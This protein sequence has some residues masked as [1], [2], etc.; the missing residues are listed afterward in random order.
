MEGI[1]GSVL[2]FSV[3]AVAHTIR[4]LYGLSYDFRVAYRH[5][6]MRLPLDLKKPPANA[7]MCIK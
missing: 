1:G 6:C 7:R 5:R 2:I 4:L 3:V